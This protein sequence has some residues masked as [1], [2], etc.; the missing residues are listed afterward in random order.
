MALPDSTFFSLLA[1]SYFL[2][3]HLGPIFSK[4]DSNSTLILSVHQFLSVFILLKLPF[5]WTQKILNSDVRLLSIDFKFS[6]K[7]LLYNMK[8]SSVVNI[9]FVSNMRRTGLVAAVNEKKTKKQK[10]VTSVLYLCLYDSVI[11]GVCNFFS[12]YDCVYPY[13]LKKN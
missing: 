3:S 8:L 10:I 9:C 5:I 7:W 11:L 2:F 13:F 6:L 12:Y 4:A 1:P